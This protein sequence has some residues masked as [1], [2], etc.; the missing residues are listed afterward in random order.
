[1]SCYVLCLKQESIP[2]GFVLCSLSLGS[3]SLEALD[4]LMQ[5]SA[6]DDLHFTIPR[7]PYLSPYW[8]SDEVLKQLP[9]TK[10]VVSMGRNV[11]S[12]YQRL[13]MLNK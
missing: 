5:R 7:D 6:S 1:M 12:L 11:L 4:S 10:I 9:T 2:N 8:A 13:Q 3:E